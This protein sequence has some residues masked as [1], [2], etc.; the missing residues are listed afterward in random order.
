MPYSLVSLTGM[1]DRGVPINDGDF[2]TIL[3][4]SR[5]LS[6]ALT[7]EENFDALFENFYELEEEMM[8]ITVRKM[9]FRDGSLAVSKLSNLISRRLMNFMSSARAYLDYLPQ[10][11]AII[12]DG[13][14]SK[15]DML[16]SEKA[17]QY[18]GKFGYRFMEAL[19]NFSQHRGYPVHGVMLGGGWLRDRTP[20]Q[21]RHW[22]SPMVNIN[23]LAQDGKFKAKILAE[24]RG[25]GDDIALKPQVREY[26]DGLGHLHQWVRTA[27]AARIVSSG[28]NIE[29]YISLY[30]NAVEGDASS[31]NCTIFVADNEREQELKDLHFLDDSTKLHDHFCTK[32]NVLHNISARFATSEEIETRKPDGPQYVAALVKGPESRN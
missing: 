22:I 4:S 17:K 18:D 27:I 26:M 3:R 14:Q 24:L 15:L 13:D 16:K 8:K 32:N 31:R 28:S 7:I 30:H 1:E 2:Q 19:R 29:Y 21:D 20:P 11:F 10:H 9:L 23:I 12:F 5:V 25:R 6:S